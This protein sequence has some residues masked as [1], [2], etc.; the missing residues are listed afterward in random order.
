MQTFILIK[1]QTIVLLVIGNVIVEAHAVL[2]DH[3]YP[4]SNHYSW[5]ND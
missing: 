1:D 5:C 3:W 2:M 4:A